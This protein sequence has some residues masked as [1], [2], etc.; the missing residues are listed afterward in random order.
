LRSAP[1]AYRLLYAYAKFCFRMFYRVRISG[2]DNI[3]KN[4][5]LIFAANHQNALMDALAI[6]FGSSKPVYFL[7]RAD[8]FR[9]RIIARILTY[10]R[11]MPVYRPRDGVDISGKN[12]EVFSEVAQML[13]NNEAIGIMP[14]GAHTHFKHLQPLKKGICRMAF[15]AA[16]L[17]DFELDTMIVPVGL[18]FSNY[19]KHGSR[20]LIM[21]GNPVKVA[22][23]YALYKETPNKA[24]AHLRD[25]LSKAIRALM[26]DVRD[27]NEYSFIM[28]YA[29]SEADRLLIK[30]N[31]AFRR[32]SFIKK[33]ADK[34]NQL[35]KDNPE[36]FNRIKQE[37]YAGTVKPIDHKSIRKAKREK[38]FNR[39]TCFL[40][41]IMFMVFNF[42][43]VLL[44]RYITGK[45]KDK[46][47]VG[48]ITYGIYLVAFPVW[49]LLLFI[50]AALLWS[51]VAG[52]III[53]LAFKL[54]DS[55]LP[56]SECR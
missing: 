41:S 34:L 45:L 43:P 54:A 42:P 26:I 6:L 30:K 9:N 5:P 55:Y 47:F 10:L 56:D 19:H 14:E 1:L 53:M 29:E 27:E 12:S 16:E 33:E 20:L 52:L 48:S 24:V 32:F 15:E 18:D 4:K 22:D 51:A 13:A 7:A 46:Q 31:D 11:L 28:G 39:L 40:L 50:T 38:A 25:D 36:E 17:K 2:T 35:Q 8:I 37:H 49:Y 21:F 3:P 44:A 23:Y